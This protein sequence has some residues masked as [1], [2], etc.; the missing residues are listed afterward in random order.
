MH[1]NDIR[2]LTIS[3]DSFF[4]YY[5]RSVCE[6]FVRKSPQILLEFTVSVYNFRT[7]HT[8][9]PNSWD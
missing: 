1:K 6:I 7:C 3:K 9:Q 5:L 4:I 2:K 8:R